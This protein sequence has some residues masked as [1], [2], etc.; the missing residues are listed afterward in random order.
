MPMLEEAIA[1]RAPNFNK[2]VF[3]IEQQKVGT[4][5]DTI[6]LALKQTFTA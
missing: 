6:A 3:F 2:P 4:E 1:Q 5:Q